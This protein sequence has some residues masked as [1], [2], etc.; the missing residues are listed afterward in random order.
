MDRAK[1]YAPRLQIVSATWGGRSRSRD[2]TVELRERVHHSVLMLQ[3]T[4]LL[5]GDPAIGEPK[6][7]KL[8]NLYDGEP[9]VVDIAEYD[10]LALPDVG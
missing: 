7:L 1:A 5:L 9:K 6:R 2:V 10:V 3:A 8:E 4:S